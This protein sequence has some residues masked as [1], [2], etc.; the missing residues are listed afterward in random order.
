MHDRGGWPTDAPIDRSEH[1]LADW[2]VLM[3]SIVGALGAQRRDERRRAAARHREHAARGVRASVVL[4]ALALLGGDDPEGEGRARRMSFEVGQR[5]RISARGHGGHHRTP[6]YVKG[7]T[8]TIVRV[9]TGR[10]RIPRPARTARTGFPSSSCTSSRSQA[11]RRTACTSTSSS[12]GWRRPSEPRPRPRPR[13][14]ADHDDEPPIADARSR[15]RRSAR[16]EGSHHPRRAPQADRLARVARSRRRRAARRARLGRSG[17]QAATARRRTRGRARGRPRPGAVPGRRRAREHRGRAPH[18]RLHAV[19]VLSESAARPAAGLVQEP[20]VSVAR[21]LRPA[22]RAPRVR[23]RAP[24]RRGGAR[25]R[26]DSRHPL[27]R[28]PAPPG[29]ERG[30]DRG[31]AGLARSRATR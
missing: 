1:E 24:R 3:D 5:V 12:T 23:C 11:T 28:H 4:R 13:S 6:D 27:P 17:V 10:S 21:R 15:A 2:E 26:L 31:R 18:G 30:D 29:R 7:K 8:G 9:A 16:R 20:A 22:R 25:R 14:R 19:L